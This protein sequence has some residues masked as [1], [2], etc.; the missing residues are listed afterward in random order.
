MDIAVGAKTLIVCM[1]HTTRDGAPKIVKKCTCP[2]T[3]LTCVDTIITD[4]AVID[5]KPEGLVLREVARG[6]TP[7]ELQ[8]VTGA[9]LIARQRIP[10]MS[11]A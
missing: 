1:E 6:W 8:A 10:E 3:A 5:V 7:E 4:L 2:L 11:F 9:P